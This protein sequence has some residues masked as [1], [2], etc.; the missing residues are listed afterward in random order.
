MFGPRGTGKSTLIKNILDSEFGKERTL[1]ID[2]LKEEEVHAFVRNLS[3]LEERL[4][5]LA[6]PVDWVVIDEVQ[7]V[8]HIL[9]T[10]HRLIE[11][12]KLRFALTGSSARKLKRGAANLL[13]G[14]A[15]VNSLHPLTHLELGDDFDLSHAMSWG[16]LPKAVNLV[17]ELEKKEF[18]RSYANTYL[19]EEIREE[20][21]V[22]KI[23]PFI[24]FLEVAAQSNGQILNYAKIAN[25]CHTDSKAVERYFEIL[26]DTMLGFYLDPFHQSIRKRQ[27]KKPKFYFFDPG[28]KRALDL[29]LEVPLRPSTSAY[30]HAFEH[31]IVLEFIRLNDYFRKD[32]RFSYLRTKDDAE[33][34]LIIERP[35]LPL[36]LIEIKSA[37]QIPDTEI[38]QLERLAR[39]FK[40]AEPF[41]LCQE[42]HPRKVGTVEVLPWAEGIRRVILLPQK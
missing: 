35:G 10:V 29:T 19:R 34:D 12:K 21:W 20:Q 41:M 31:W 25:D 23:E 9:N 4:G 13:A 1:W 11:Q 32:Y 8:P 38:H 27:T 18:L 36:A 42:K 40:G 30:G 15:F 3:E 6:Q 7:R 33:I 26:A 37:S 17:A 22:R 2:F 39:D 28:V 14:R 24:R 5:A 16:T